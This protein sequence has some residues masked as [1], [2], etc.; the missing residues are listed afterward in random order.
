MEPCFMGCSGLWTEKKMI[1]TIE[2]KD[3]NTSY[4]SGGTTTE[5]FIMPEGASYKDR[6]FLFRISTARVEKPESDFTLLPD[7]NRIIASLEGS[8]SLTDVCSGKAVCILPLETVYSFDG[9]ANTHCVGCARDLNLMLRKGR[10]Y[11]KAEFAGEGTALHFS[12]GRNEFA[13]VFLTKT[14][15]A[16]IMNDGEFDFA[17][18]ELSAVFTVEI[19]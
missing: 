14:Q 5:I 4:W 13:V 15:K 10:A 19:S 8:M 3:M 16:V 1:K 12:L 6:D 11:G 7:Y 9:G 2:L 18:P 17:A